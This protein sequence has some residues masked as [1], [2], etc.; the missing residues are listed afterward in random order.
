[1]C[2]SINRNLSCVYFCDKTFP[3]LRLAIQFRI[4]SKLRIKSV[5][6]LSYSLFKEKKCDFSLVKFTQNIAIFEKFVRK[7]GF[8]TFKMKV[9]LSIPKSYKYFPLRQQSKHL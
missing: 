6:L 2:L 4:T 8:D 1:M 7:G 5:D 9:S 3:S